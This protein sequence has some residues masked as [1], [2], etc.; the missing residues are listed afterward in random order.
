MNSKS[1]APSL[2]RALRGPETQVALSRRLGQRTNLVHRWE[3]GKRAIRWKEFLDLAAAC[4]SPPEAALTQALGYPQLPPRLF[5]PPGPFSRFQCSRWRNGQVDPTLGQVLELIAAKTPRLVAFVEAFVP[6]GLIAELRTEAEARAHW[7]E[8]DP[9]LNALRDTLRLPDYLNSPHR[10][11]TLAKK[12]RLDP[13]TLQIGLLALEK[14]SQIHWDG[15][16]YRL[17]ETYLAPLTLACSEE[18]L[19]RVRQALPTAFAQLKTLVLN[20]PGEKNGV[21]ELKLG[22]ETR[23]PPQN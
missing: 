17:R 14:Q 13:K 11:E 12:V 10:D 19:N 7:K 20:A 16:N 2:C 8:G 1:L 4:G 6:L 18:G 5:E 9:T 23:V 21:L 15:Q 22:V 3:A